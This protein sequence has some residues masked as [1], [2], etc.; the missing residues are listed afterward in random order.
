MHTAR[1]SE[2]RLT[3]KSPFIVRFKQNVFG[4]LKNFISLYLK[5]HFTVVSQARTWKAPEKKK[6]NYT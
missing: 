6:E 1:V 3:H 4:A 5:K 2:K